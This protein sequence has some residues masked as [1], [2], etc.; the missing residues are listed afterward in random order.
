MYV[1]PFEY[2]GELHRKSNVRQ[3]AAAEVV[4]LYY[5]DYEVALLLYDSAADG[6]ALI[7]FLSMYTARPDRLRFHRLY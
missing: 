1:T 4:G 5:V 2:R 6:Q 3:F 7:Y